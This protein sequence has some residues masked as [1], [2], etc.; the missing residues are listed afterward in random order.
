MAH[1]PKPIRKDRKALRKAL[2]KELRIAGGRLL[3]PR[4]GKTWLDLVRAGK[5][6][7][8]IDLSQPVPFTVRDDYHRREKLAPEKLDSLFREIRR[9]YQGSEL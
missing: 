8:V 9:P 3:R 2:R 7:A 1:T 4:S 5:L 6:G